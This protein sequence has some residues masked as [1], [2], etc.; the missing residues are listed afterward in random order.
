MIE[1]NAVSAFF[2]GLAG[3]LHCLGMCGG[4][5]GALRFA[6]PKQASIF[7]YMMSYNLGRISSYTIA[8]GMTGWLG[9]MAQASFLKG[10]S[11][12]SLLSGIMLFIMA[13]YIGQWWQ[14]LA[15]IEKLGKGLWQYIRPFSQ[16]FIP[17]SSP[18]SALPY[19]IIWGWLPC[20][21]VYSTLTWS[22]AAG[23]AMN[24]AMIMAMF[25]IG[26][27]PALFVA[28]TGAGWLIT[29]L[30]HPL[31]RT[32]VSLSLLIY[33]ILLIYRSISSIY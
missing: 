8:G 18:F 1:F 9:Q 13:L 24:G 28:G 16:R 33:S 12:L 14:G 10:F 2:I 6:I 15:K 7:P 30:K 26:T 27:L 23:S 5:A 22:L 3:S 32:L 20:G 31:S 19:G 25:G 21:L 29:I 17:F 4:V 11:I